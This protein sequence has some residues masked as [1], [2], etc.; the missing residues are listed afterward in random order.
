M[1]ISINNYQ[2]SK[3]T[4]NIEHF[5]LCLST[6]KIY[7]DIRGNFLNVIKVYY[8]FFRNK[9]SMFFKESLCFYV[10]I[11]SKYQIKYRIAMLK[12]FKTIINDIR[13]TNIE[14]FC[15]SRFFSLNTASAVIKCFN[16]SN[17]IIDA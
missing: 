12:G 14:V 7:W 1:T 17:S 3:V 8:S 2:K 15:V 11:C 5:Q 4:I 6:R 10:T 9:Y 13:M 16:L